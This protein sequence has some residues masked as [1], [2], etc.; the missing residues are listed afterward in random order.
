M[1]LLDRSLHSELESHAYFPKPIFLSLF[2][3]IA[4]SLIYLQKETRIAH[5]DIKPENILLDFAKEPFLI[6]FG[7]SFLFTRIK[8]EATTLVGT[9]D[10]MSPEI[11]KVLLKET[12][13][14]PA[15][16]PWKSDAFSFGVTMLEAGGV[17]KGK[18]FLH[19]VEKK[20]GWEVIYLIFIFELVD[21]VPIYFL[22]LLIYLT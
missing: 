4:S 5:R 19:E 14:R 3:K 20:Y 16:D 2:F 12:L 15:Y 7:E 22:L 13:E 9:P 21:D 1:P 10:Y 11:K 17:G 18:E 8:E 6:D